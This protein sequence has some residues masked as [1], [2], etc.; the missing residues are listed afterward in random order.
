MIN[1]FRYIAIVIYNYIIL[2]R[3]YSW[4][5]NIL[6]K[7]RYKWLVSNYEHI[8]QEKREKAQSGNPI[9]V[10]FYIWES[11][12]WKYEGLYRLLEK[13]SQFHPYIVIVPFESGAVVGQ[14]YLRYMQEV[15]AYYSSKGYSI[16]LPLSEDHTR[17]LSRNEAA[18]LSPDIIFYMNCWHE[19]GSFTQ[20]GYL[21]NTNALQ[22]YVP[23]AWMISNRYIEH[24]NRDFH[25]YMWK[26]FYET[27]I[28]VEM[29]RKHAINKGINA[30]ASGYPLLDSF[31]DTSYV[32][33]DVWKHQENHKKRIIWAPHHHMLEK[34]RCSN[35][36]FIY[37]KMLEIA[38]KYQDKV[39][40]VFKPHPELAKKLDQS[41]PGWNKEKRVAYYHLWETMPNTQ[42]MTDDYI[43]LFLTS[44]A[45][46]HDCGSFTA[47][48]LCTYKPM[49]FLEANS[50]VI[51]DWNECG[52]EIAKNIY[53][54]EKGTKI[55]WFIQSVVLSGNDYMKEQRRR[56]VDDYLRPKNPEGAST[57]I[58]NY[59]KNELMMS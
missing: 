6:F 5:R 12:K 50:E 56:F 30:I 9:N 3:V 53:I 31:F 22:A 58:Y 38:R 10:A 19:Y 37:D 55:E 54:S 44:D 4:I 14:D 23:Y 39:Q 57:F 11:S 48:Y 51:E 1:K 17:V 21:E 35:F 7:N 32:P 40:F 49:L 16:F 2:T 25:N 15:S 46:I 36:L 34:N 41:I 8:L 42:I 43:D 28:H 24:F 27:Q 52:K 29:A 20:F 47:E 33:K 18:Q 13:D 26:I 59:I 45:I